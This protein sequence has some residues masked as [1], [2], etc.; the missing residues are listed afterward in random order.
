MDAV[1]I[2]YKSKTSIERN[3]IFNSLRKILTAE[4]LFQVPLSL[5]CDRNVRT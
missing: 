5:D 4:I 3:A 1:F 2:R